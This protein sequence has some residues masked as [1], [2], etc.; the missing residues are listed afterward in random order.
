MNASPPVDIEL[1]SSLEQEAVSSALDALAPLFAGASGDHS[2]LFLA[3]PNAGNATALR[4]WADAMQAGVALASPQLFPWCLANAPCA[5]LARHF[6]IT[7]P[8]TTWLGGDDAIASAR[9]AAELAVSTGRVK[10]AFVVSVVFA[11]SPS[12]PGRLRLW[13]IDAA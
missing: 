5:A 10:S 12:I 3:S 4:F 7:G 6:G 11:T 8:S 2:G 13:R 1:P 9:S